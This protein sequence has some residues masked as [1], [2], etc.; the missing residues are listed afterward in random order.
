MKKILVLLLTIISVVSMIGVIAGYVLD[1]LG[2]CGAG[3]YLIGIGEVVCV[4]SASVV[5][6]IGILSNLE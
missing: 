1:A 5:V 6:A 3:F 4:A 2:V